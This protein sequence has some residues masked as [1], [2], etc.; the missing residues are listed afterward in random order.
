M[1]QLLEIVVFLVAME[2]KSAT[3]ARAGDG[4]RPARTQTTTNLCR[5]ECDQLAHA[6]KP[7]AD[8][9]G[10]QSCVE[11]ATKQQSRRNV[12]VIELLWQPQ[13]AY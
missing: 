1:S 2:S 12:E 10:F 11:A 8:D 9:F 3:D 6:K 13:K 7:A 5:C 4:I